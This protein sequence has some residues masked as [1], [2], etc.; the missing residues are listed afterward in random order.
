[1]STYHIVQQ[2]EHLSGI[3]KRYGFSDYRTIW[4]HAQNA[5]LKEKRQNPNVIFPDDRLFIPDKQERQEPRPTDQRHRF[6]VQRPGLKL[7][8]VLEDLY[9]RPIGNAKC[10]LRVESET[11]QLTTD[12]K[13]RIEQTIAPDAQSASLTVRDPQTPVNEILIAIDIGH[14]DPVDEVSGQTARLNNL[15]YFAGPA[16]GGSDEDNEILFRSAV[17]EFQCEHSLVVDG[18]CG[19]A[20]QARLKQVHGS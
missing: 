14:L 10:D 8:L 5:G 18:K 16:E 15:G 20:T 7:R 12:A 6:R 4:L 17:E 3:A 11:H 1:M 19:P 13:G 9:E 2:G